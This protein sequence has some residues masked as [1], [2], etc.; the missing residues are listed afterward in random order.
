MYSRGVYRF[1]MRRALLTSLWTL[2]LLLAT[3]MLWSACAALE[4]GAPR[5]DDR[6]RA[7][8]TFLKSTDSL[9]VEEFASAT[10]TIL[11]IRMVESDS[12]DPAM[13]KEA[14]PLEFGEVAPGWAQRRIM[15]W[16]RPDGTIEEMDW[17]FHAVGWPFRLLWKGFESTRTEGWRVPRSAIVLQKSDDEYDT[18]EFPLRPI[19]AGQLFYAAFWLSVL[20]GVPALRR[21]HRRRCGRC[22]QCGYDLRG[23]DHAACPECGEGSK[24]IPT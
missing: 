19:L 10:Q 11:K 24:G 13:I 21:A 18:L 15:R 20:I 1:T 16:R 14:Y 12:I 17:T 2:L 3:N 9:S 6:K 23:A 8:C 22:I 4:I 5:Y 7:G